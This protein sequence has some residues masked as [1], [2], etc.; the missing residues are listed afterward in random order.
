M[1]TPPTGKA[2]YVAENCVR[3]ETVRHVQCT[4]LRASGEL[5]HAGRSRFS[6]HVAAVWDWTPGPVLVFDLA[7]L[8]FF[9]SSVIGVLAVALQRMRAA[10]SGRVILVRPSAHLLSVLRQTDLLPH[11]ELRGSVEEAVAELMVRAARPGVRAAAPEAGRR[12]V[13]DGVSG[14]ESA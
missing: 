12:G 1:R 9:D 8:M 13:R 4:V 14:E 5:D 11:V 10:E 7:E 2:Y 6:A 3:I